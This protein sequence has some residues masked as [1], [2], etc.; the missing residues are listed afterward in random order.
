MKKFAFIAA[1]A[2]L[3]LGT[4]NLSAQDKK[5]SNYGWKE[6]MMSEKIGFITAKLQLTTEE[7]QAF[8]PVY[9][10]ISKQKEEALKKSREYYKEMR[11][12]IKDGK[13]EKEVSAL[14]DKYMEA[15]LDAKKIEKESV[16]QYNK[17]LDG[18]KVA[19][20]FIAEEVFRKQQICRLHNGQG[21][22]HPQGKP[23]QGGKP[24]GKAPM[25]K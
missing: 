23:V 17:V 3:T 13:S 22:H 14:L 21:Q 10:K 4:L 7:A 24:E 9:N 19:K 20:L 11:T 18:I 12:A 6:K 25:H 2:I 5:E 1:A 15:V 16:P 8:W